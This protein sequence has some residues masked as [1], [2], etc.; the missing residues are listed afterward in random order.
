SWVFAI[1]SCVS[2][3]AQ[4]GGRSAVADLRPGLAAIAAEDIDGLEDAA[5]GDDIVAL[6]GHVDLLQGER[7]RRLARFASRRGHLAEGA[8]STCDGCARS[9]PGCASASTPTGRSATPIVCTSSGG[10][11]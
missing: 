8:A 1:L 6:S 4:H 3:Q 7:A 10:S 2:S 11:T 9:R 5:L